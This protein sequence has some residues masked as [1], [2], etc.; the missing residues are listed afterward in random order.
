MATMPESCFNLVEQLDESFKDGAIKTRFSKTQM[1][2][3]VFQCLVGYYNETELQQILTDLLDGVLSLTEF[4]EKA[5]E[6]KVS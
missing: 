3:G 6:L 5:K 4:R 2:S 1:T